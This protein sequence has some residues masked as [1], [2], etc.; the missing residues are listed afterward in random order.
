MGDCEAFFFFKKPNAVHIKTRQT[1]TNATDGTLLPL[2]NDVV[3]GNLT[4][5]TAASGYT[6]SAW[7]ELSDAGW[8]ST[9]GAW[10]L[11]LNFTDASASAAPTLVVT[12][13]DVDISLN[14][15]TTTST[16][17]P[18]TVVAGPPVAALSTLAGPFSATDLMGNY[19]ASCFVLLSYVASALSYECVRQH[20][21]GC[22]PA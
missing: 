17:F 18:V 12:V 21:H 6:V 19:T 5:L 1:K 22:L 16:P 15:Y 11:T 7:E 9:L 3:A 2:V 14:S 20:C 10:T 8:N 13:N 4:Y